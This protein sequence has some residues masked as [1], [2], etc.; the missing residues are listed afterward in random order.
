MNARVELR[1][2][3]AAPN[4]FEVPGPPRPKQRPRRGRSGRWY[5]PRAT[6]DYEAAV[7]WAARAAGIHQPCTSPVRLT[8]HLV[9][10]D[11]RRRDIDN[12][13]K[14]VMDGLNGIVW[15]DDSQVV[16]LV[17][18]REVDRDQPRAEITVERLT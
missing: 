3:L 4:T 2:G 17:V 5:T 15:Y 14:A 12:A 7:G 10:P 11:R 6:A 18:T 9:F 13:T 8:L 16:E 1:H